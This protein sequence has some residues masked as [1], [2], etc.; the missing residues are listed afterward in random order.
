MFQY[1]PVVRSGHPK[2]RRNLWTAA[3]LASL[4]CGIGLLTIGI[5]GTLYPLIFA[6]IPLTQLG[7]FVAT[8]RATKRRQAARQMSR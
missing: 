6:G 4:L 7:P 1:W 3:M 8:W 2:F 5:A